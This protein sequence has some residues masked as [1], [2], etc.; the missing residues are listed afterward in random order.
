[1]RSGSTDSPGS[2]CSGCHG[3]GDRL[4]PQAVGLRPPRRPAGT[5]RRSRILRRQTDPPPHRPLHRLRRC[6]FRNAPRPCVSR[7]GQTPSGG[8]ARFKV[9]PSGTGRDRRGFRQRAN[10]NDERKSAPR[11]RKSSAAAIKTAILTLQPR[12]Q[13]EAMLRPGVRRWA[14]PKVSRQLRSRVCISGFGSARTAH[15]LGGFDRLGSLCSAS[16]R[17]RYCHAVPVK[18]VAFCPPCGRIFLCRSL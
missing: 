8:G 2:L 6:L 13:T 3:R 14:L 9:D 10:L 12:S 11:A 15:G 5:A 7:G 1:M 16:L 17:A 4:R 18:S